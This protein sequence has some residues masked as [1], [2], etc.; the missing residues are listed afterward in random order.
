MSVLNELKGE[1]EMGR[2][3]FSGGS[4]GGMTELRFGSS[5]AKE[6]SSRQRTARRLGRRGG[7]NDGSRRWEPMER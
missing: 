6:G 5:G 1:E 2:R 3:Q 7:C 4:E